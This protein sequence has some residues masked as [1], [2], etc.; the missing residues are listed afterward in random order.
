MFKI[1]Y[2]Y[3]DFHLF[4]ATI[5]EKDEK[6]ERNKKILRSA[7]EKISDLNCKAVVFY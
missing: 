4:Q 3:V 5:A 2:I 1:V 6:D 7:K